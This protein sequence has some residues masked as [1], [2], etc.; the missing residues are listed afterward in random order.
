MTSDLALLI[1]VT[2]LCRFGGESQVVHLRGN[3]LATLTVFEAFSAPYAKRVLIPAAL[4]R[5]DEGKQQRYAPGDAVSLE[6]PGRVTPV[7]MSRGPFDV[8]YKTV[9]PPGP[10][11]PGEKSPFEVVVVSGGGLGRLTDGKVWVAGQ[12]LDGRIWDVERRSGRPLTVETWP[13]PQWPAG[14]E[15]ALTGSIEGIS[16]VEIEQARGKLDCT[17][18]SRDLAGETL[19]WEKAEVSLDRPLR[20]NGHAI[21][22]A[23]LADDPPQVISPPP[24]TPPTRSSPVAVPKPSPGRFVW[25]ATSSVLLLLGGGAG[26]ARYRRRKVVQPLAATD[27]GGYKVLICYNSV[28]R[29]RVLAVAKKLRDAGLR[30]W[31]DQWSLRPGDSWQDEINK[32][33]DTIAIA[34]VFIGSGGAGLFEL[35]EI[36]R[37]ERLRTH[38]RIRVIPVLLRGA[39]VDSP[40]VTDYLEGQHQVD[41]RKSTPDP[42]K[43]LVFG[44]T[45]KTDEKGKKV[46]VV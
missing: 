3:G 41:F 30:P 35:Q 19:R 15:P 36:K 46:D 31:I 5:R 8:I 17:D 34:L 7:N 21:A 11:S 16:D 39:P 32:A 10:R 1:A 37:L 20:F 33:M 23:L 22:V 25:V 43:Q 12:L 27:A 2:A 18:Q 24:A 14:D 28:D 4:V 13:A 6:P 45:G 44:I 9:T 26:F 40:A 38:G 42:F 29:K